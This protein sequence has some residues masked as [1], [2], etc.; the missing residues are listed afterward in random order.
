MTSNIANK[1]SYTQL[2][3]LSLQYWIHPRLDLLLDSLRSFLARRV[4]RN[5]DSDHVIRDLST[6]LQGE[7]RDWTRSQKSLLG[8]DEAQAPWHVYVLGCPQLHPI[9][10]D[11]LLRRIPYE[12][13]REVSLMTLT[14]F[15]MLKHLMLLGVGDWSTNRLTR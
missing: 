14:R 11:D 6:S 2:N 9:S 1:T 5:R 7:L 15:V 10:S 12:D 13:D 8:Q 3:S 4:E